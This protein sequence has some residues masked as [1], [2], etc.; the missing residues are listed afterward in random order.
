MT[1]KNGAH[2]TLVN[3]TLDNRLATTERSCGVVGERVGVMSNLEAICFFFPLSDR[4]IEK[5]IAV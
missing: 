2:D 5:L 1:D 3:C 4:Q